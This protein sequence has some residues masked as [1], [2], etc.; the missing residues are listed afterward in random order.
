MVLLHIVFFERPG[1]GR[2]GLI[3]LCD[4]LFCPE[5]YVSKSHQ[6]SQNYSEYFGKHRTI[7]T[8]KKCVPSYELQACHF[9]NLNAFNVTNTADVRIPN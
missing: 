5:L 1:K 3:L 2:Y 8:F 4:G 7:S 9:L 6:I